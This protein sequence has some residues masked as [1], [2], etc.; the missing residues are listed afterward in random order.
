MLTSIFITLSF[1]FFSSSIEADY[2]NDGIINENDI[3]SNTPENTSVS[4]NGCP[5]I[6]LDDNGVTLK[7]TD[8]AID[9]TGKIILFE[10]DEILIVKDWKD[11]RSLDPP[12]YKDDLIV[13]TTFLN[14]LEFFCSRPCTISDNFDLSSW[15]MSNVKSMY[16]TFWNTIGLKQDL[17]KWDVSNVTNMCCMFICARS[18]NKDIG[19]WDV[20]SVTNMAGMFYDAYQFNQDIRLW[21][22]SSV[23]NMNS[24]FFNS[25]NFNQEINLWD[26]SNVT[27]MKDMF[28]GA[29]NF[30]KNIGSWKLSKVTNMSGMFSR[31]TLFNNDNRSSIGSWDVSN[32]KNMWFMFSTSQFNGDLSDWNV[33][34]VKIMNYVKVFYP[35]GGLNVKAITYVLIVICC[36]EHGNFKVKNIKQV[37]EY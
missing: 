2:D 6:Y 13:V 9:S 23:T 36:L 10:G 31:A 5:L 22:V 20:S 28:N 25:L 27:I 1:G 17:S 37:K 29:L 32:V 3:C 14:R 16:F 11:I 24:M 18:F 30:N 34:N 19:S 12:N 7:A 4:T 8:E 35:G 21:V 33:S 15:D 26:V